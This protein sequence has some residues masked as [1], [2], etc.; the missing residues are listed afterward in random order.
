MRDARARRRLLVVVG[1]V[2][3]LAVP[4]G[5]TAQAAPPDPPAPGGAAAP[6][7]LK[8]G[9]SVGVWVNVA[10]KNGTRYKQRLN[11]TAVVAG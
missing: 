5:A 4:A 10:E 2:L 1:L 11:R 8:P 9:S 3:A 7:L 6:E